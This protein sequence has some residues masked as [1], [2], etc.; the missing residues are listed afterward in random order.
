MR[1]EILVDNSEPQIYPLNK[2]KLVIGSHE[3][4]DIVLPAVG[5]S[6]KHLMV[7]SENDNYFVIDQGSANGSY[8]NDER[9]VPGNKVEFTSFF[10]VRISGNILLTLL[11]DEESA[12][13]S[14]SKPLESFAKKDISSS[15]SSA[16]NSFSSNEATKAISLKD[17]QKSN[18][19]NLI[20]KRTEAV[21]KKKADSSLKNVDDN[22]RM[23]I[24]FAL[25]FAFVAG[26][27]YWNL[28]LTPVEKVE[29]IGASKE[30]IGAKQE[31]QDPEIKVPR[32]KLVDETSIPP[33]SKYPEILQ[34][35]PCTTDVEK[36]FCLK[37]KLPE[38]FSVQ[39]G[40]SLYVFFNGTEFLL[41][42]KE[43]L[44][45]VVVNDKAISEKNKK[46][47]LYI[48]ILL[49]FH[50][51]FPRDIDYQLFKD[52][53]LVFVMKVKFDDN[54]Y[55]YAT[56]AFVPE[57]LEIFLKIIDEGHFKSAQKYGIESLNVLKEYFRYH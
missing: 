21:N 18:T 57:T 34:N 43:T 19:E 27:A 52:L 46:D 40:S 26:A 41:P 14:F 56:L 11:S 17:L 30:Q 55:D 4:C 1:I 50:R 36:H 25:C 44:P 3:S 23:K 33:K 35:M 22:K 39:V 42:A 54:S 10:P 29:N 37:I 9:L 38:I 15:T 2:P 53:D 24:V 32:F 20:R 48:A 45:E 6:R 47:L 51:Q 31:V 5:V 49:Y 8:I 12:D 28:Y 13:F 7:I 16:A